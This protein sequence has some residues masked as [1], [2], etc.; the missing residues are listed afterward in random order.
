MKLEERFNLRSAQLVEVQKPSVRTGGGLAL[1]IKV[2]FI[3][4][5]EHDFRSIGLHLTPTEALQ[6]AE[7]L[8]H[9]AH[10]QLTR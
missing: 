6:L 2:T 9:C 1:G 8:I 5:A 3:A 4:A 10:H 7:D